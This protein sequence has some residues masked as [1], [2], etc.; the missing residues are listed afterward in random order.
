M[1]SLPTATHRDKFA[2]TIVSTKVLHIINGEHYAGAERVQDLLAQYLGDYGYNIILAC[3]KPAKFKSLANCE[4]SQIVSFPMQSKLD[5][6]QSISIAKLARTEGVEL[7]HTHTVRTALIGWLVSLRTGIPFVHH[8]HS[9]AD[10]DTEHVIRNKINSALVNFL[11]KRAR[12]IITVSHDLKAHLTTRGIA[13]GKVKVILNGVE[14]PSPGEKAQDTKR[15]TIGILALFRPRK[16]IEVLLQSLQLIKNRN[17]DFQLIVAGD[18]ETT[19]YEQEI[20]ALA[21]QMGLIEN[22]RWI[23]FQTDISLFFAEID[24]FVLPSLSGEGLP[25]VVLESMAYGVP[26][27]CSQLPGTSDAIPDENYGLLVAPGDVDELARCIMKLSDSLELRQS[28]SKSARLRQESM[29]SVT[30]MVGGVAGVY[31][32]IL[33]T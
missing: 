22:I 29:L 13:P 31:A 28:I 27:V 19:A 16:G 4:A 14:T 1:P 2:R 11:I 20:K 10:A 15:F 24:I 17:P 26:V 18:F 3:I 8:V 12:H 25:M 7:L 6:W 33:G 9:P 32:T 21:E 30:A 5:V 23:G